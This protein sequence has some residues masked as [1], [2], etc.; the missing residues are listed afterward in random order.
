MN[1]QKLNII[2][3]EAKTDKGNTY[4]KTNLGTTLSVAAYT[5]IDTAAYLKKGNIVSQ[6]LSMGEGLLKF[7]PNATPKAAKG[8][9]AIGIAIDLVFAYI[10]GRWIDNSINKKRAAK[11]DEAAEAAAKINTET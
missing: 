3:Y 7:F 9:R 4:K 10:T 11:A 2:G 6:M 1:V 5:A 8:I